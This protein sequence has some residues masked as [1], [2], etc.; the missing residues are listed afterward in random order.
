[1]SLQLP[2]DSPQCITCAHALNVYGQPF[3]SVSDRGTCN[4][5]KD[6]VT[7]ERASCAELRAQGSPGNRCG[8]GGA[9]YAVRQA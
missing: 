7:G 8:P 4:L 1:M 6:L 9:F 5:L 3:A 2:D